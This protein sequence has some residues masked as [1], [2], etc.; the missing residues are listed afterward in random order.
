MRTGAIDEFTLVNLLKLNLKWVC[1]VI[2]V[3][4]YNMHLP[5]SLY[6]VPYDLNLQTFIR[7]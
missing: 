2:H 6:L 5:Y 7:F 4:N 1:N 3:L